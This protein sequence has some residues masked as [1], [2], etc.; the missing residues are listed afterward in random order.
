MS[1]K[2]KENLMPVLLSG[3]GIF[4]VRGVIYNLSLSLNGAT[5][6]ITLKHKYEAIS[7]LGLVVYVGNC[8]SYH[9]FALERQSNWRQRYA[10]DYL[11]ALL[12][13]ETGHTWHHSGSSPFVMTK[14]GIK[15]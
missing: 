9:C 11:L 5:A 10:D 4:L 6:S 2:S 14:H 7:D 8:A 12:R 15:L 3:Q 1:D 13:D